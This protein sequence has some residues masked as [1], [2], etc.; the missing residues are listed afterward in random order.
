M[1]R[2]AKFLLDLGLTEDDKVLLYSGND[3]YFPILFWG[4]VASGCIFTPCTCSILGC[5]RDSNYTL[6]VSG[7][8]FQVDEQF[9]AGVS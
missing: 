6:L 7:E 5:F 8:N 4:A 2:L 9:C 1:K 3:V